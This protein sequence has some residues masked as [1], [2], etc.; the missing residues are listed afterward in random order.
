MGGQTLSR[1]ENTIK[2]SNQNESR[3]LRKILDNI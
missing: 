2:I 3:F 1:I